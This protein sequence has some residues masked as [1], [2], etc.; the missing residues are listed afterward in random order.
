MTQF[1][2]PVDSKNPYGPKAGL[3]LPM[4]EGFERINEVLHP[5]VSM[6]VE[7]AVKRSGSKR[8]KFLDN[9]LE[10]GG[11]CVLWGANV[12]GVVSTDWLE[13]KQSSERISVWARGLV[14]EKLSLHHP[15]VVTLSATLV[16]ENTHAGQDYSPTYPPNPTILQIKAARGKQY[17]CNEIEAHEQNESWKRA[18]VAVLGNRDSYDPTKPM[19][20]GIDSAVAE[21]LRSLRGVRPAADRIKAAMDLRCVMTFEADGDKLAKECYTNL[22]TAFDDILTGV[23]STGSE[24]KARVNDTKWKHYTGYF[25]HPA[26]VSELPPNNLSQLSEL[27]GKGPDL[28]TGLVRVMDFHVFP[29]G[30]TQRT[31]LVIGKDAGGAGEL[32]CYYDTDGDQLFEESTRQILFT[33]ETR[34][35][36]NM[37]LT[38]NQETGELYTLDS[39][40]NTLY[41]L[42]DT[43]GD[44]IP[45]QLGR[46]VN[47]PDPLMDTFYQYDFLPGVAVPTL[48]GYPLIDS[49]CPASPYDQDWLLLQDQDTDGFF[50]TLVSTTAENVAE[51]DPTFLIPP[52]RPEPRRSRSTACPVRRSRCGGR[53]PMPTPWSSSGLRRAPE[54]RPP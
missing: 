27:A 45:D 24:L 17:A 44:A 31:L 50:E 43:D 41:R 2:Y 16:H 15:L 40:T 36:G 48:I 33:G 49:M 11:L 4:N 52:S 51:W 34:L 20:A 26:F 8:A 53:T 42:E 23:L 13:G 5:N 14:H 32:Q 12:R 18:L 7:L 47:T 38:R 54:Y 37:G 39:L 46:P 3:G 6:I 25:D 22:K 1:S 29:T 9:Q 28:T 21:I 19:P 30:P 10:F 35:Q